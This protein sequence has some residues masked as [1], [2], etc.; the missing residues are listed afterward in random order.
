MPA[1]RP[2]LPPGILL[3]NVAGL[4]STMLAG[5]CYVALPQAAVGMADPFR[6]DFAAMLRMIDAQAITSLILVPEYLGGLVVAMRHAGVRLPRLT[7]VAVG[8]A[9]IDPLL[10]AAAAMSGCRCAKGTAWT[11]CASVVALDDGEPTSRGSVGRSIGR[12]HDQA[13]R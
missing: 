13:G 2:L 8:G 3:E 9:R 4:Y 6:P 10:L 7:L 11:E 5:G 12:Q 1:A